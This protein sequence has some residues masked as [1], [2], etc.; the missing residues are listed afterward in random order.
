[1]VLVRRLS[2]IFVKIFIVYLLFGLIYIVYGVSNKLNSYHVSNDKYIGK[3]EISY[4]DSSNK[5]I[6]DKKIVALKNI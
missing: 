3:V 5:F 2:F 1:M 4:N 6:A